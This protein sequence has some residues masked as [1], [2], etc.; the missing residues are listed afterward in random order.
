MI[1]NLVVGECGK[2]ICGTPLLFS[3]LANIQKAAQCDT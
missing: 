1:S 3:K 2:N